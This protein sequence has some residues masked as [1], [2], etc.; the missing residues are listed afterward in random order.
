MH[1]DLHYLVIFTN[2][3]F[4][5]T[6]LTFKFRIPQD[7]CLIEQILKNSTSWT[8]NLILYTSNI[9]VFLIVDLI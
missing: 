9:G 2:L 4:S 8:V 5:K 6:I 7:R 3:P 1:C